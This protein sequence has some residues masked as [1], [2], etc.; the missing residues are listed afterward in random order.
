MTYDAHKNFAYSNVATAPSP[1]TSG[2]SLVV[3]AGQGARFPQPSTDGAFNLVIW[4]VGSIPTSSNSEIV[5][6]T[7]RS[8]DT[9]TI[10]RTQE[11]TVARTVIVGDQIAL[12]PTAK[13]FTDIETTV[14]STVDRQVFTANGT[15]TKPTGAR[16]VFAQ[17]QAAGGA[18]GGAGATAA[19]TSSAGS[20]GGGGGYA[21][22]VFT[23][24]SLGGTEAVVVGPNSSG[25]SGGTGGNGGSSSFS[26]ISASGGAGGASL[27]AGT[28]IASGLAAGGGV[29]SG[30][31]INNTGQSGGVPMRIAAT[32][33]LTG[34][35]GDSILGRGGTPEMAGAGQTTA[36]GGSGR[37]YGGGGAGSAA[38]AGGAASG[39][40]TGALG[41]VIVT[42]YIAV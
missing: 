7:A 2:T 33:I 1:A 8:T 36:Q 16:Y 41:I 5:R 15:W 32:T 11:S 10:T 28:T 29:G 14:F 40:N 19:G 26:T 27:A 37:N 24:A 12:A 23:A 25:V 38:A 35:G 3:T 4:P 30:G 22:K 39:G 9:L 20:G 31:D 6:V 42:T 18:G 13:L 17:V 34:G 21:E